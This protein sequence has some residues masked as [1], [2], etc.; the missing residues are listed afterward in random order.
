MGGFLLL[1]KVFYPGYLESFRFHSLND[2]PDYREGFE[3]FDWKITIPSD[4]AVWKIN[5]AK[6][7]FRT[8]DYGESDPCPSGI[9][10]ADVNGKNIDGGYAIGEF[11]IRKTL[12][13]KLL[14]LRILATGR[15]SRSN[16]VTREKLRQLRHCFI[17]AFL[18]KLKVLQIKKPP[19]EI[20]AG[21]F[22]KR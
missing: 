22:F 20:S 8:K 13:K 18:R 17:N 2:S 15:R 11:I 7:K 5:H 9:Y 10:T 14:L 3:N 12:V 4:G 16:T 19:A 1:R 21:G 6:R